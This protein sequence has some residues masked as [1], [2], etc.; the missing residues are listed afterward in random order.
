MTAEVATGKLPGIW[1]ALDGEDFSRGW[2]SQAE[3]DLSKQR[4]ANFESG[5]ARSIK[6]G[7][8]KLP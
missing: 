5:I 7:P 2:L 1:R 6:S 4:A 3:I 8:M